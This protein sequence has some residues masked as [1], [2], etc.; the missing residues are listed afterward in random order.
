MKFTTREL[1][2]SKVTVHEKELNSA[3]QNPLQI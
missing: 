1:K 2:K 3:Y